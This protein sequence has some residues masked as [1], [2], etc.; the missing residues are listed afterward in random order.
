MTDPNRP[1]AVDPDR[2]L[3]RIRKL[4]QHVIHE[5]GNG[6]MIHLSPDTVLD[7]AESVAQLDRYLC[8]GGMPPKQWG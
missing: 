6:S 7:L 4:Y 3:A 2:Q 5:T 8:N 1:P